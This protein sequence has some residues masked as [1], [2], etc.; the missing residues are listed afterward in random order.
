MK[1]DSL[2]IALATY[3]LFFLANACGGKGT[4]EKPSLP[5]LVPVDHHGKI[6][7]SAAFAVLEVY[8]DTINAGILPPDT[9]VQFLLTI[10]NAG[11]GPLVIHRAWSQCGCVV[12]DVPVEPIMPGK[13]DTLVV[14]LKTSELPRGSFRRSVFV[15]ANSYP[16]HRR[17]IIYGSIQEKQT[18]PLSGSASSI[19]T[20][21]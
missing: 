6:D 13:A 3:V 16:N 14:T 9:I 8:P 1:W 21:M 10:R 2:S 7:S 5:V 15:V 17:V 12:T 18:I 19:R 20:R 4:D 11:S